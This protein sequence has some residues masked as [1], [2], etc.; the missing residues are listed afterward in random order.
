MEWKKEAA[1]WKPALHR[2]RQQSL[3]EEI[4]SVPK[5]YST[6]TQDFRKQ[7]NVTWTA[8]YSA[9]SPENIDN[10][11]K[12]GINK[13][14]KID[15]TPNIYHFF[16]MKVT[17]F[18]FIIPTNRFNATYLQYET[19]ILIENWDDSVQVKFSFN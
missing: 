5:H 10:Q 13:P 16:D 9:S 6:W 14:S 3:K 4:F 7:A 11:L 1:A 19:R 17:V 18:I 15:M 2:C 12:T 8:S